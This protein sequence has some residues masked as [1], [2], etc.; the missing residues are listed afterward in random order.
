MNERM[1]LPERGGDVEALRKAMEARKA[2][3]RE[4]REQRRAGYTAEEL[5]VIDRMAKAAVAEGHVVKGKDADDIEWDLAEL[6]FRM[7][8]HHRNMS[9]DERLDKEKPVSY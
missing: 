4:K 7:E 1:P 6:R 9:A 2:R 5:A 8:K 3:E